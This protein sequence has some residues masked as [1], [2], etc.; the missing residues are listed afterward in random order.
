MTD[1]WFESRW[2]KRC[3]LVEPEPDMILVSDIAHSLS[4]L[5]RFN[6][7]CSKFYSVAEHCLRVAELMPGEQYI[8][9]LLHDA[10]EAWTGDIIHPLKQILDRD[11]RLKDLENKVDSA[12]YRKLGF[13][14]PSEEVRDMIKAADLTMLA[15]ERRDLM[16][17]PA[18]Q[19]PILE[20]IDPLPEVIR[21]M[22][23]PRAKHEWMKALADQWLL[24]Q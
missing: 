10:H 5:C 12:I 11:G 20:G 9:G 15:T 23:S 8:H 2:G 21:P 4:N 17:P 22:S 14:R 24:W 19:W 1:Y 16:G 13:A 3:D 6:G 18:G 7:H